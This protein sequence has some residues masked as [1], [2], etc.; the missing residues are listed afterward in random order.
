MPAIQSIN[1]SNLNSDAFRHLGALGFQQ[2][3]SATMYMQ[4]DGQSIAQ[5]ARIHKN[6]KDAEIMAQVLSEFGF[7]STA[8][9]TK[10]GGIRTVVFVP[11]TALFQKDNSNALAEGYRKYISENQISN[12]GQRRL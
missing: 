10:R 5:M 3:N 8:A 2:D 1:Y 6:M 4:D 12:V 7:N 9:N 11:V